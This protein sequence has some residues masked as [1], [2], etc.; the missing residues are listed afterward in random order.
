MVP[1]QARVDLRAMAMNGVVRIPQSF[2]ITGAS[3]LDGLVSY[4][5]HSLG[6]SYA[7]AEKHNL[8]IKCKQKRGGVW[9]SIIDGKSYTFENPKTKFMINKDV[10]C[11]S[12]NIVYIMKCNKFKEVYI[13]RQ[14]LSIP[15]Y[16]P[17]K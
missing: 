5:G 1:S 7:S 11:D 3:S 17:T 16:H 14:K 15:G 6:E 9:D 13:G 10:S 2:S 8:L 12:K 4:P